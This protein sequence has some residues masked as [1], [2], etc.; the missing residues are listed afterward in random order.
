MRHHY[1]IQTLHTTI[2]SLLS[3]TYLAT[4]AQ[5]ATVLLLAGP[6]QALGNGTKTETGKN[7]V[8]TKGTQ[9]AINKTTKTKTAQLQTSVS[10]IR[11]SKGMTSR[12]MKTYQSADKVKNTGQEQANGSQDLEEWLVE[13]TPERV[14]LLLRMRHVFKLLLG[15]FDALGNVTSEVLEDFGQ[16]VLLWSGLARSSLVLGVGCDAAVRVETLDDALGLG[17]DATAFL[18]QRLDFPD[19]RLFVTLILGSAFGL[20]DFLF[21]EE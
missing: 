9:K 12:D 2:T 21:G 8:E 1:L 17:E 4:K 6:S 15:V 13:E 5:E 14:E 11:Q 20:V 3:S 16:V 18:D 7:A 19:E 10:K